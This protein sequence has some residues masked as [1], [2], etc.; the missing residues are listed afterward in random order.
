MEVA[1]RKVKA[2][3]VSKVRM[4]T[5]WRLAGQDASPICL[6][7]P[8]WAWQV[9]KKTMVESIVPIMISLKPKLEA[10]RS[11][12]QRALLFFLRE[13]MRD[14]KDDMAGWSGGWCD[15]W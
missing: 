7:Y 15:G 1:Q 11:P 12:L 8:G 4:E 6:T 10:H 9:A 2:A 5:G 14:H 3:F 13:V